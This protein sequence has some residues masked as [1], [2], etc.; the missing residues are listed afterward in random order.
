LGKVQDID[1]T[2]TVDVGYRVESSVVTEEDG[3][4]DDA[5]HT[6]T[7]QIGWTARV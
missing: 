3:K 2:V 4:V 7:V 5:N 1:G 6:V